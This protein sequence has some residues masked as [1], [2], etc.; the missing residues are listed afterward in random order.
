MTCPTCGSTTVDEKP[1]D[2]WA[3]YCGFVDGKFVSAFDLQPVGYKIHWEPQS[4]MRDRVMAFVK[5]VF[6]IEGNG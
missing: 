3:G 6:S 2:Y 5:W 4:S 1:Q